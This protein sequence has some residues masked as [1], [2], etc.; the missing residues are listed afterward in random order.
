VQHSLRESPRWCV[1]GNPRSPFLLA[2]TP[3]FCYQ[4]PQRGRY[5]MVSDV[6]PIG[7]FVV[8]KGV[9][10]VCAFRS[11]KSPPSVLGSIP[12]LKFIEL[13]VMLAAGAAFFF[14]LTADNL[15]KMLGIA[16]LA[17]LGD[18][19]IR[20]LCFYI[21]A[22]RCCESSGQARRCGNQ[23][24]LLQCVSSVKGGR[25]DPAC[26][27]LRRSGAHLTRSRRRI[28]RPRQTAP[29]KPLPVSD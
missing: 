3:A 1:R 28:F 25:C 9:I 4:Q 22:R 7:L 26:R 24:R 14:F 13:G 17:L 2:I 27:V 6:V 23:Y 18:A 19:A 11:A 15:L 21:T 16:L 5:Y 12:V 29:R 8:A 10:H 20:S